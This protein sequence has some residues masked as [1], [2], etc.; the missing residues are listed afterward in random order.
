MKAIDLK[1]KIRDN[2]I[3][4]IKP[5]NPEWF[6]PDHGIGKDS[7]KDG[8]GFYYF[9][10]EDQQEPYASWITGFPTGLDGFLTHVI[11]QPQD[12]WPFNEDPCSTH[13]EILNSLNS[14]YPISGPLVPDSVFVLG[15]NKNGNL[16]CEESYPLIIEEPTKVAPLRKRIKGPIFQL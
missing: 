16:C 8:N 5:K 1:F 9:F 6:F 4:R 11:R 10:R 13:K 12:R 2:K 15:E 3:F 7:W 14:Y